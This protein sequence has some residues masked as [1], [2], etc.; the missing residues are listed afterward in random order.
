M[1]PDRQCFSPVLI[2]SFLAVADAGHFTA[3]ARRLGLS[4]S[5]ISQHVARL[6]T[7]AGR[8]LLLRDT[9]SVSLTPDGEA[10]AVFGRRMV[11]AQTQALSYFGDSVLRG[12]LRFG[13]SEDLALSRLPEILR[14]FVAANPL[15]DLDLIV[16]LSHVLHDRL[17]AGRVDLIFTKLHGSAPR[18]QLVWRERLVWI[19]IVQTDLPADDPIPLVLYSSPTSITRRLAT[20][21]LQRAGRTWRIACSTPS[22]TAASAAVQ[23]GLGIMAQSPIVLRDGLVVLER[24]PALDTVDFVVIGR[25]AHLDGPAAA[26]ARLILQSGRLMRSSSASG[27]AADPADILVGR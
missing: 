17:E 16:D 1:K 12:R 6:E 24:L 19:G 11:D 2:H 21:A 22:L 5:T 13:V 25:S 20:E 26:L 27:S 9:H 23:A 4:Q 10:M 8:R 3:A 7:E 15:V 14:G 18:G